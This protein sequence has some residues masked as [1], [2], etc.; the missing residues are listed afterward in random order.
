MNN[1]LKAIVWTLFW[2]ILL[3]LLIVLIS[4]DFKWFLYYVEWPIIGRALSLIPLLIG[5]ICLFICLL[6]G[7]K[8]KS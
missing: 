3:Y 1:L 4:L 7:G 5:E 6:E 8:K 2:N